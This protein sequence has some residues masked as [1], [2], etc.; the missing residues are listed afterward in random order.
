MARRTRDPR[1]LAAALAGGAVALMRTDT[2]PGLHGRADLDDAVSRILALKAR[3]ADKPLLLLCD[4]PLRALEVGI[5]PSPA[6]RAY[7]ETC[8]PGPFTLILPATPA[9]PAAATRGADTVAVRVPGPQG[10]RDLVAAAGG[11]LVS[12]SVNR[13]GDAPLTDLADAVAFCGDAV[14]IVGEMTW[15]PDD[16][17]PAGHASGL[18]DLSGWPPRVLRAGRVPPPEW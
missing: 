13:A 4:T 6:A 18:I 16:T 2:L 11:P 5:F 17:T 12:T 9:A 8:W 14:D 3:D 7:A 15:D 10:L 1:T